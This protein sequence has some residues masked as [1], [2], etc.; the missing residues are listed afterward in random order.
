MIAGMYL[1]SSKHMKNNS[2]KL[3]TIM[4]LCRISMLPKVF[5]VFVFT[6]MCEAC[7]IIPRLTPDEF[8]KNTNIILLFK[9]VLRQR[10]TRMKMI[11]TRA[12]IRAT[13]MKRK[14]IIRMLEKEVGTKGR[15]LWHNFRWNYDAF[16]FP[17]YWLAMKIHNTG[18]NT[19]CK[20]GCQ[21][22]LTDLPNMWFYLR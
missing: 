5:F 16:P 13:L 14:A 7:R 17:V 2:N 18:C 21:H 11:A 6:V 3:N 12:K 22:T 8:S 9:G 1:V 4:T 10:M 15:N 19:G 20:P